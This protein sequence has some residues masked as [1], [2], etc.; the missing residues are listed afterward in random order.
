MANY[1]PNYNLV[2][3]QPG[4]NVL[5]DIVLIGNSNTIIDTQIKSLHD[6]DIVLQ[7]EITNNYTILDTKID[8]QDNI[9]NNRI[10]NIILTAAP[11]PAVAAQEVMD[12]RF[13]PVY[14]ITFT[15]LTD[16]ITNVEQNVV[17]LIDYVDT[18]IS[19]ALLAMQA[20]IDDLKTL[21]FCGGIG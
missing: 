13:S 9:I 19:D 10:D 21:I 18:T 15:V 8:T 12:S 20:Q 1:T 17:D 6:Q 11:L 14:N 5:A 2:I 4:D 3:P 7:S 16:R